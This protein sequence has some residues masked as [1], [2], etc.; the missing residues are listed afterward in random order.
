MIT[1]FVCIANLFY[2]FGQTI[3]MWKKRQKA[4]AVLLL[5]LT[6]FMTGY[7]IPAT[8]SYWPTVQKVH[9][10]LYKPISDYVIRILQIHVEEL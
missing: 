2:G 9:Q 5:V 10:A 6:L 1:A 4:E 8:A 7:F 3:R